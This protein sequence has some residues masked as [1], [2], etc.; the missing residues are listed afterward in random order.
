MEW[1]AIVTDVWLDWGLKAG[2]FPFDIQ[3]KTAKAIDGGA[4]IVSSSTMAR[5]GKAIVA[6][7]EHADETRNQYVYASSSNVTQQK[8]LDLFEKIDGEKWKVRDETS[9]NLINSGN[10][11]MKQGDPVGALELIRG[12]AFGAG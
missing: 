3:T 5:I 1:S 11:K 10:E 2:L 6:S 7:L 9:K 4:M 12:V 8:L